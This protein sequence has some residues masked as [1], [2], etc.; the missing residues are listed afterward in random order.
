MPHYMGCDICKLKTKISDNYS[1]LS[2][3]NKSA[4]TSNGERIF[5]SLY[6]ID[7]YT[8]IPIISFSFY[9]PVITVQ[10]ISIILVLLTNFSS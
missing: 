5:H 8:Y 6:I 10:N 9:A 2:V 4:E 1:L 7:I 3:K